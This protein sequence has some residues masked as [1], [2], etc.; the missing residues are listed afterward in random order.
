MFKKI[1]KF[2]S[3][4]M[5]ISFISTLFSSVV[6]AAEECKLNGQVVPCEQLGKTLTSFLGWG[7]IIFVI[8]F[9]LGILSMVFLIMMIVHVAKHDVE[10][11]AMW[12]VIMVLTGFIGAI[13]Y[14]FV[15][16]KDFDKKNIISNQPSVSN[17]P[18][19]VI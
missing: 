13:V 3:F 9:T 7:I 12:I 6:Y 18:P 5:I 2:V 11:K 8:F 19:A 1:S 17:T 4:S 16:K 10:N 15:I 14:Y